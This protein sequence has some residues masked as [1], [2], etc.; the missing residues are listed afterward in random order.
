MSWWFSLQLVVLPRLSSSESPLTRPP[1]CRTTRGRPFNKLEKDE[2]PRNHSCFLLIHSM[3]TLNITIRITKRKR[4]HK[5]LRVPTSSALCQCE[6][7]LVHLPES[8]LVAR[9]SRLATASGGHCCLRDWHSF[10]LV[11]LHFGSIPF[12]PLARLDYCYVGG[13]R[14]WWGRWKIGENS[15]PLHPPSSSKFLLSR[16][17]SPTKLDRRLEDLK[18]WC[19][20]GRP[21]FSFETIP[22]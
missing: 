3:R 9:V 4:K 1:K 17:K 21:V 2:N 10:Y 18:A 19:F 13:E 16:S 6:A 22:K 20:L 14:Q 15:D 12:E 7:V 8:R 5:E 11:L